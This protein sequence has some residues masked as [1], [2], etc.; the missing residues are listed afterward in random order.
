MCIRD[1]CGAGPGYGDPMTPPASRATDLAQRLLDAQV[2]YHLSLLTDDALEATVSQAAEALL[3]AASEHRLID[4][5][6]RE[7][8]TGF[9]AYLLQ[10]VPGSAA[11]VS[12]V[13]IGT[14]LVVDGPPEPFPLAAA[15]DL[16]LIHI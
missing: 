8:V 6:D 14:D 7:T 9:A 1:R 11:A 10:T 4:L 16:S 2:A 3:D 5:V 12:V 13:Q 15:V